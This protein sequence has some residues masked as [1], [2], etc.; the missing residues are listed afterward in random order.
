MADHV[1]D[2]KPHCLVDYCT[3]RPA[4]QPIQA[5]GFQPLFCFFLYHIFTFA[6]APF[7]LQTPARVFSHSRFGSGMYMRMLYSVLAVTL[8]LF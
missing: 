3:F 4:P 2:T 8:I 5:R 1:T 6:D 7:L